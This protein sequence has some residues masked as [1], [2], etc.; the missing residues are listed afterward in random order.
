[1]LPILYFFIVWGPEAGYKLSDDNGEKGNVSN[2]SILKI[3]CII[4]KISI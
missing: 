2:I 1:M 3:K 4:N